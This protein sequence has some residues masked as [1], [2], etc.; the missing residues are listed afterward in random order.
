MKYIA[1]IA[2]VFLASTSAVSISAPPAEL[3]A[4]A[5][6]PA[7]PAAAAPAAAAPGGAD[8][9]DAWITIPKFDL[10]VS[11]AKWGGVDAGG[12]PTERVG[13]ADWLDKHVEE[14]KMYRSLVPPMPKKED[15]VAVADS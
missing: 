3:G 1:L 8:P 13:Q 11:D 4:A 6:A 12:V 15:R 7:A 5:A 2:L 10:K 14:V 9:E